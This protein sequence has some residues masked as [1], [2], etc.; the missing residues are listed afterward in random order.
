MI[1]RKR[2]NCRNAFEKRNQFQFE[3]RLTFTDSLTQ[4][5]QVRKSNFGNWAWL[6]RRYKKSFN[7][8]PEQFCCAFTNLFLN[9]GELFLSL[10]AVF[11]WERNVYLV[12][13]LLPRP[14]GKSGLQ[15]GCQRCSCLANRGRMRFA[16][17]IR[18]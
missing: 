4:R 10:W 14:V 17:N 7:F 2:W 8:S 11:Y 6:F 18:I 5:C 1:L 3:R 16:T 12:I 13:F 15:Q 9:T